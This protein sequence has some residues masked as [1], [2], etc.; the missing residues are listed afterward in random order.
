[1]ANSR[2]CSDIIYWH[3]I[4]FAGIAQSPVKSD[5]IKLVPNALPLIQIPEYGQKT[6]RLINQTEV[7]MSQDEELNEIT[8]EIDEILVRMDEKIKILGDSSKVFNQDLLN[9]EERELSLLYQQLSQN[10]NKV[11]NIIDEQQ[12]KSLDIDLNYKM[13][14]LTMDSIHKK[15]DHSQINRRSG[16]K[17][18]K[19]KIRCRKFSCF[20][21]YCLI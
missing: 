10:K 15:I 20:I 17:P 14:Q 3:S 4:S 18:G 1:M 16:Y 21:K 2:H 9:K 6:R 12:Q 7:L 19:Y 13:W 8:E 11:Q 5:S